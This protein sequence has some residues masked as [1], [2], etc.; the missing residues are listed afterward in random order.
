MSN[1]LVDFDNDNRIL[2]AN[3]RTAKI[4]KKED[5]RKMLSKQK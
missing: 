2:S 3:E 4:K 1:R 5:V